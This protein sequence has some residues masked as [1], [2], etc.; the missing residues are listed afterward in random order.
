MPTDPASV[1]IG[2]GTGGAL[3][4]LPQALEVLRE[5]AMQYVC[6]DLCAERTLAHAQLARLADPGAG[7]WK[8]LAGD[9][10]AL[11]PEARSQGTRLIGSWGQANPVGA[12]ST[13]RRVAAELG[14][15]G[16]RVGVV[17]GDDVTEVVRRLDPVVNEY[18]GRPLSTYGGELVAAHAYLGAKPIWEALEQRADVV[19]TGR[20]TDS[21]LFVAPL[22]HEFGWSWDELDVLGRAV[23]VGHLLECGVQ[24]TGGNF[25]DPPLREVPRLDH[26]PHAIADVAR[27]GTAVISKPAGSGG[28]VSTLTCKKQLVHEI[29]DPAAYLTPEVAA[30]FRHVTLSDDGPDRVRVAGGAGSA[31][32]TT[33]KVLA[34]LDQGFIAEGEASFAGPR[35]VARAQQAADVVLT[36]LDSWGKPDDLRVDLIGWDSIF[37]AA[38]PHRGAEPPEVR[39]RVALRTKVRDVADG[40]CAEFDYQWL[41]VPGVSGV[42]SGV[43]PALSLYPVLLPV[44]ELHPSVEVL[45]A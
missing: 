17:T 28:R 34:A 5:P 11:L 15:D 33:A 32:P 18:E 8:H 4:H 19:V 7:F 6:F 30:D 20:C 9:M 1:R 31:A 14:L 26:L 10:Q 23:I 36:R 21:A 27:D 13:V 25:S 44:D 2:C 22:V 42:R 39:L 40:L 24:V 16:L 12:A 3:Y 38:S 35:A 45:A 37:S 41:C 43:R 29:G